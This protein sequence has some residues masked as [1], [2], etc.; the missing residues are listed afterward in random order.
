MK[1]SELTKLIKEEI[2]K[3]LKENTTM[4][5]MILINDLTP[6]IK[7]K[8]K[9]LQT[10]YPN[11]NINITS[12]S[13]WKPDRKDLAGTYTLSYSGPDDEKLLNLLDQIEQK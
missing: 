6:E 4:S 9:K 3:V 8:I 7:L 2:S 10:L 13:S 11:H 5:G 12:N 1:K